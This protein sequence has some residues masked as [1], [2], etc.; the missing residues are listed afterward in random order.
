MCTNKFF[1]PLQWFG[2]VTKIAL[3][4]YIWNS[5]QKKMA[6]SEKYITLPGSAFV[7]IY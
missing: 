6:T 3:G 5:K 2:S 1:L 7:N 4:L